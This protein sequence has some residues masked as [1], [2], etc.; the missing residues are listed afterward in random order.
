MEFEI[1]TDMIDVTTMPRYTTIHKITGTEIPLVYRGKYY[2]PDCRDEHDEYTFDK[3]FKPK[4][5][6]QKWVGGG[7]YKEYIPGLTHF[8]IDGI[9]VEKSEFESKSSSSYMV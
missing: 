5:F 8:Y 3:R 2:C 9:E 7:I 6:Q 1:K 4:N